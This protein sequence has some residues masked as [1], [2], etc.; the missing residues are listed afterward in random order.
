MKNRS[1][2]V[3]AYL[4]S[5]NHP[6]RDTVQHLRFAILAAEPELT[7]SV[8]WNAPNFLY[9]GAD[10]VTF[11]L[12]PTDRIQLI[13]HRGSK[14]VDDGGRFQFVDPTG[15]LQPIT[16]ERGQVVFTN[17][18]DALEQQDRLLELIGAWIRS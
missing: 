14:P 2:Q 8:K 13:F 18:S 6:L 10:R 16:P 12:R 9:S 5:L 1:S 15:L 4:S 7:E 11:N 17:P 3:D